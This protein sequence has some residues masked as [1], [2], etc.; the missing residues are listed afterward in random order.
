VTRFSRIS[1]I[2]SIGRVFSGRPRIHKVAI[3]LAGWFFLSYAAVNISSALDCDRIKGAPWYVIDLHKCVVVTGSG[4]TLA[5]IMGLLRGSILDICVRLLILS[6]LLPG[7]HYLHRLSAFTGQDD[8]H[9]TE[10]KALAEH[11]LLWRLH[12]RGHRDSIRQHVLLQQRPPRHHG[13]F[14]RDGTSSSTPFSIPH[15]IR[16][17]ADCH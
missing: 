4:D 8:A 5:A 12:R 16:R 6:S 14:L 2:L 15:F 13:H 3:G 1:L 17:S 7:G 9:A 11:H 10:D